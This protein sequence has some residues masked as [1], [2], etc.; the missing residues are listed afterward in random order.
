M[1][2]RLDA[3]GT[4][5]P[6]G[7]PAP[8]EP[9]PEGGGAGEGQSLSTMPPTFSAPD[10]M[11]HSHFDG[12]QPPSPSIGGE[13]ASEPRALGPP[14]LPKLLLEEASGSSQLKSIGLMSRTTSDGH[15]AVRATGPL[16]SP[17][18]QPGRIHMPRASKGGRRM[19]VR[20]EGKGR[21]S[22]PNQCLS[23]LKHCL[24]S[25]VS[26]HSSTTDHSMLHP[27]AATKPA[28]EVP[29]RDPTT[30][31]IIRHDGTNHLGL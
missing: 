2:T 28:E 24:S 8:E 16:I 23:S 6:E 12:S 9:E 21:F 15:L 27:L 19:S 31:T 11:V 25:Q 17:T 10:L 1:E 13:P 4:P 3:S 20:P 18:G 26:V 5:E 29:V 7:P 30:W 22:C 14:P